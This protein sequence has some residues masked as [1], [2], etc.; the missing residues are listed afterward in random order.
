M[1]DNIEKII[2][3]TLNQNISSSTTEDKGDL[4]LT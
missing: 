1:Y 3:I 4:G 2:C